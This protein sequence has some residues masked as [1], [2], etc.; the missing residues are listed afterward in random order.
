MRR[1]RLVP[2]HTKVPFFKF[3]WIAFG[4]SAFVLVATIILVMTRGLE[5]GIDFKGGTLIEVRT[6]QAADLGAMRSTL[7]DLGLGAGRAAERRQ[8]QRRHDPRRAGGDEAEQRHAVEIIKGAV[9]KTAG[10]RRVYQRAEFVG[11][12]VSGDCCAAASMPC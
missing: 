9:D 10:R 1:L 2:D 11:P 3:R 12:K 4:W 7:N 5:F 6:P 8:R